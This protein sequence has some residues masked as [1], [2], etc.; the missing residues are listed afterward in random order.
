ML[1]IDHVAI[2]VPDLDL[3]ARDFDHRTGLAAN[4]ALHQ[5]AWGTAT[6][7]VPLQ[8]GF[9]EFIAVVNPL[10]AARSLIGRRVAKIGSGHGAIAAWAVSMPHIEQVAADRGLLLHSG[11]RAAQEGSPAHTWQMAGLATAFMS[12]LPLLIK[13]GGAS[14]NPHSAPNGWQRGKDAEGF[15]WIELEGETPPVDAWLG[16]LPRDFELRVVSAGV[17]KR[18]AAIRCAGLEEILIP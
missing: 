6:R 9:L 12:D 18:R 4:G 15:A 10:A 13:W 7:I 3:A 16:E 1:S 14:V 2:A 8:R 5:E 17:G 11:A